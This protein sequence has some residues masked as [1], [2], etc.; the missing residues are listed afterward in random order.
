MLTWYG[1]NNFFVALE[2]SHVRCL[3]DILS[4]KKVFH[5]E[6]SVERTLGQFI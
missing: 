3:E 2:K 6:T 1:L 4:T 5:T